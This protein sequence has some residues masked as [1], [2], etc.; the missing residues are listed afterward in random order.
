MQFQ[1]ENGARRNALSEELVEHFHDN[2][3]TLYEGFMR[4]VQ[5]AGRKTSNVV[6]DNVHMMQMSQRF[7]PLCPSTLKTAALFHCGNAATDFKYNGTSLL[8]F[9]SH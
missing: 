1:G 4:G 7:L 8:Q 9:V 6:L 5:L 2:V 3:N